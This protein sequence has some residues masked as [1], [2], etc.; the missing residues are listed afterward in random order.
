MSSTFG[1]LV[2]R[3]EVLRQLLNLHGGLGWGR[4]AGLTA[5]GGVGDDII[6]W[7]VAVAGVDLVQRTVTLICFLPAGSLGLT[8][9]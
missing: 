8:W 3:V 6:G 9:L 4:G 7:A 5:V 1:E 2:G